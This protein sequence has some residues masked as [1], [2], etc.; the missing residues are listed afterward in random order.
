VATAFFAGVVLLTGACFCDFTIGFR[1]DELP[2][3]L[4]AGLTAFDRAFDLCAASLE[5]FFFFS[6]RWCRA[7]MGWINSF[8]AMA[9]KNS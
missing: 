1:A 4:D 3:C 8:L 7:G 2:P 6:A 5:R 9:R